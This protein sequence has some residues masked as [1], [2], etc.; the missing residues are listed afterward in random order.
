MDKILQN[1]VAVITGAARGIGAQTA[2]VLAE[3]GAAVVIGDIADELGVETARNLQSIHP[4]VM[5]QHAD[6]SQPEANMKLVDTAVQH[7][8][9]LDI[10]VNNAKSY[11]DGRFPLADLP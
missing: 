8:G 3:A 5:Y 2:R 9:R 6:I 10:W 11:V 1:K 4:Q 7:F